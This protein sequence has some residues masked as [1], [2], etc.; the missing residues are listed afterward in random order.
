MFGPIYRGYNLGLP[1]VFIIV[2]TSCWP[3]LLA[4]GCC[5]LMVE[6]SL[7]EA[8]CQLNEAGDV[9]C[10][11]VGLSDYNLHHY[12]NHGGY[13]KTEYNYKKINK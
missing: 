5:C 11:Y 13:N 4:V 1:G 3:I 8:S 2:V 12:T 7:W 6:V 9:Y 10:M